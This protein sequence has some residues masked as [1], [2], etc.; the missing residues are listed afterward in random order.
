VAGSVKK[1]QISIVTARTRHLLVGE[2]HTVLQM[3]R[4]GVLVPKY[5]RNIRAAFY[6]ARGV[7]FVSIGKR[8][9]QMIIGWNM[10]AIGDLECR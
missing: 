5:G 8:K 2:S 9:R 3:A 10:L 6:G 7:L 4:D 1:T